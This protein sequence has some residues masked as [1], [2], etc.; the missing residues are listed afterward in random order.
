VL[1]AAALLVVLGRLVLRRL[2]PGTPWWYYL[3]SLGGLAVSLNTSWRF[4][5]QRLHI[6]GAERLIMFS[7]VELALVACALGMRANV[8]LVDPATGRH[9]AAGGPRLVAWALCGL[10]AYAALL[11]SGPVE[12]AARVTLGPVLSLVMLHLALG[13]EIR[14]TSARTGT[15]ARVGVE[16]RERALSRFGLGDDDRDAATRTRTRATTRAARLA[17]ATRAPARTARLARALRAAGIAHDP[18]MREQL[19]AELAVLRHADQLATLPL[20]SP[21]TVIPAAS[22]PSGPSTPP[23]SASTAAARPE[24]A[25]AFDA[26]RT[27]TTQRL[28]LEPPVS[29]DTAAAGEL[30]GLLLAAHADDTGHPWAYEPSKNA[31]VD[32]ADAILPGRSPRSL[33]VALAAVDVVVAESSVR[34]RRA[35]RADQPAG[36]L[37]GEHATRLGQA[38][39]RPAI[40]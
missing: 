19:L 31:A 29:D 1:A 34:R 25:D 18:A 30:D 12:G 23:S 32:R 17:L 14:H 5:G 9:G 3:A 35:E 7:V 26:L 20:D 11:L 13:I 24:Q 38:Q 36:L 15:W 10:S 33:V 8:R 6:L 16:I 21:W 37:V 2:P 4:F 28:V 39:P 22:T 40:R 27:L